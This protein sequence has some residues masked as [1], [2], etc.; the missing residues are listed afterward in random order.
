[1][2]INRTFQGRNMGEWLRALSMDTNA[3]GDP[4]RIVQVIL[5]KE[6]HFGTVEVPLSSDVVKKYSLS[7]T[8]GKFDLIIN[9][10][11]LSSACWPATNGHCLLPFGKGDLK[12]GSNTMQVWFM[13]RSPSDTDHFL[14]ATGP[15]TRIVLGN[16]RTIERPTNGV[17]Q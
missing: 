5:N 9:G 4:L 15:I 6:S 3:A 7:E 10:R 8:N 16:D 11:Q 2:P 13:I 14:W 17:S 12:P 1:R